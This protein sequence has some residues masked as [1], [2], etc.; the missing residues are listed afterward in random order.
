MI[1][2]ERPG[3]ALGFP[4][5]LASFFFFL[6]R[7][8]FFFWNAK[9]FFFNQTLEK[10]QS[11]KNRIEIS[12]QLIFISNEI[13]KTWHFNKTLSEWF[14]EKQ[15]HL[16]RSCEQCSPARRS[17][18][19]SN[20]KAP[21]GD[22]VSTNPLWSNDS[23]FRLDFR[24]RTSHTENPSMKAPSPSKSSENYLEADSPLWTN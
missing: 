16:A 2:N 7:T 23:F 1:K 4:V 20:V 22:W 15:I 11:S 5:S 12:L 9:I 21:S 13:S 17:L 6:L 18:F 3:R 10:L 24:L 8:F 19:P 14:N